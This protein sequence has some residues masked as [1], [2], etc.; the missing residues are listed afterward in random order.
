MNRIGRAFVYL[1]IGFVAEVG[2]SAAHDAFR[3]R[4]LRFR[5]SP[6]M[7]PIY[8]L[9]QPL[10]EPLHDRLRARP[11]RERA[12]AYAAG[13]LTVEYASGRILRS[14]RGQAPWDYS[15][16]RWNLDG[17]VRAEYIL[18]WAAAGL[19]LEPLHDALDR[20]E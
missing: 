1:G 8:A 14:A 18:L 16:A 19:A 7:L 20:S 4:L 3:G 6:W 2:Y 11:A 13:F 9:L 15:E 12:A 5:T 10:Y 17:L